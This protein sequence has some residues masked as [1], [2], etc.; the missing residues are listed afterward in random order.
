M[1]DEA[2]SISSTRITITISPPTTNARTPNS[3]YSIPMSL[4]STVVSQRMSPAGFSSPP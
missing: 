3:P 4:W 2:G 1:T